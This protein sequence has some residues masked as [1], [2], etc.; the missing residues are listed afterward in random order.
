[1]GE[2]LTP[3]ADLRPA[4]VGIVLVGRVV[5]GHI[6]ATFVDLAQR[7]FLLIDEVPDADE[8]WLLTDVRGPAATRTG[9]LPFEATLLDG[10]FAQHSAVRLRQISQDLVPVLD[11]ARKQLH[12]D[13]VR[14]GRLRRWRRGR[15]TQQGKRL[16]KQIMGFRRDLRALA[17]GGDSAAMAGLAAY[18]ITFGI[19]V[20]AAARLRAAD[21][22]VAGRCETSLPWSQADGFVVR[23]LGVCGGFSDGRRARDGKSE[24]FVRGWSAP[25]EH[26]HGSHGSHGHGAAHGGYG[27]G[28]HDSGGG[29]GGGMGGGGHGGH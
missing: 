21:T 18:A 9:L 25:R 12:R 4:Q 19:P 26:S 29:H 28:Y 16:L 11:R 15:R 13:A 14:S 10:L 1:M 20:P 8:D 3:P 6:G 27:G 7:G 5:L 23:W 22:K 2:S 24:D 17:A